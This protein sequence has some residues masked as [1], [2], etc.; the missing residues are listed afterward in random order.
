VGKFAH[1]RSTVEAWSSNLNAEE[2]P[3]STALGSNTRTAFRDAYPRTRVSIGLQA[4]PFA[5]LIWTGL[6]GQ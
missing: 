5:A 3:P 2:I 4:V 6:T 1:S